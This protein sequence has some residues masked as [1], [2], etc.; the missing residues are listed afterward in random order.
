MTESG[1]AQ[2]HMHVDQTGRNDQTFRVNLFN[3]GFWI[4]DFGFRAGDFS[5]RDVK[6]GDFI[7]LI[8]G[9]DNPAVPNNCGVHAET[10]PQ[11]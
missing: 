2:M 11:R 9:I 5:I 4:S 8:C 1:L 6:I 7:P 10:P 3:F